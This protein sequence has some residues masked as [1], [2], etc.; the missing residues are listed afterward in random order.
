MSRL[1]DRRTA[2]DRCLRLVRRS[3]WPRWCAAAAAGSSPSCSS[4][5]LPARCSSVRSCGPVARGSQSSRSGPAPSNGRARRRLGG[6][7]P[8][9][10]CRSR[11]DLHDGVAHAMTTINVQAGAAA[12][13]MDRHPEA[14]K[15]ALVAIRRAS[16]DVLDELTVM[17]AL[18][19][20]G[21]Q[22]PDLVPTPG[23]HQIADL[24]RGRATPGSTSRSRSTD[25]LAPSRSRSGPC[26]PHRAGVADQRV[27]P[28]GRHH[29]RGPGARGRRGSV[30]RGARRRH[31]RPCSA[32][33]RSAAVW[34]SG[35][36]GSGPRPPA[37]GWRPAR[38]DGGFAVKAIWH[39]RE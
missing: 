39:G 35:G 12:H 15:E 37:V 4:A 5:G 34:A 19:R 18:L 26:V 10:A 6:G 36:C 29:R 21:D 14:A 13:V 17:V 3:R 16:G 32:A 20:E 31:R 30:G 9:T 2:L 23:V 22:P 25:R 28:R 8:R 24:V 33:A 7:S 38:A 27:A 11:R 1:T